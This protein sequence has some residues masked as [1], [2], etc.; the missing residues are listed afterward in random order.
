MLLGPRLSRLAQTLRTA[1]IN[2]CK[3]LNDE[4]KYPEKTD[5]YD[6]F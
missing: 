2:A 1:T 4:W 6:W 5:N 3:Y